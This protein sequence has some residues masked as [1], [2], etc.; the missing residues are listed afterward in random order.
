MYKHLKKLCYSITNL[1]LVLQQKTY[2]QLV[3]LSHVKCLTCNIEFS[4][5]CEQNICSRQDGTMTTKRDQQHAQWSDGKYI[6]VVKEAKLAR[7]NGMKNEGESNDDYE[8][9]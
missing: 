9:L 1:I 6:D 7:G 8:E 2:T 5:L 4:P 3:F